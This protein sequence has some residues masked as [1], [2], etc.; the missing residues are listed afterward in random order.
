VQSCRPPIACSP[1]WTASDHRVDL[2]ASG[3]HPELPA[4][5]D[6]LLTFA[7]VSGE[8][9]A[10]KPPL[11]TD[12][13]RLVRETNP[14]WSVEHQESIANPH[15]GPFGGSKLLAVLPAL[16]RSVRAF[17]TCSSSTSTASATSWSVGHAIRPLSATWPCG[18]DSHGAM[19]E[20]GPRAIEKKGLSVL[21]GPSNN[22]STPRPQRGGTFPSCD[23]LA[24]SAQI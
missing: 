19:K 13:A 15:V 16:D 5:T 9:G 4:L 23:E 7:R 8:Q 17:Q 14:R 18:I 2:A 1:G 20:S 24:A 21:R 10:I 3:H 12:A 22:C 11:L 6:M